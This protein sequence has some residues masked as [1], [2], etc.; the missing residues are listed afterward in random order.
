MLIKK[1]DSTMMDPINCEVITRSDA[2]TAFNRGVISNQQCNSV[3][4]DFKV[5]NVI[6]Q[7]GSFT[8]TTWSVG[9]DR[10]Q[11]SNCIFHNCT[12]IGD[13]SYIDFYNCQIDDVTL[14]HG[15]YVHIRIVD[16]ETTLFTTHNVIA[17]YLTLTRVGLKKFLMPSQTIFASNA[18]KFNVLNIKGCKIKLM[19]Q[20]STFENCTVEHNTFVGY[21][22]SSK[23]LNT[24]LKKN[25]MTKCN[26]QCI[27]LANCDVSL[28]CFEKSCWPNS[29]ISHTVFLSSNFKCSQLKNSSITFSQFINCPFI[30]AE[31]EKSKWSTIRI[32][33]CDFSNVNLTRGNFRDI[34][35]ESVNE[36]NCDWK[37]S[38][39]TNISRSTNSCI[40]GRIFLNILD[41]TTKSN[42][43]NER[44]LFKLILY[45]KDH[46]SEPILLQT[47]QPLVI[48]T[49]N[50][51][52]YI[53]FKIPI[54]YEFDI[55]FIDVKC[56]SVSFGWNTFFAYSQAPIQ[57]EIY[58]SYI[59]LGRKIFY[60]KEEP[61]KRTETYGFMCSKNTHKITPSRNNI[62][63][64]L[65]I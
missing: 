7:Q 43:K 14:K 65:S 28:C 45:T 2:N 42:Y 18:T 3:I 50:I 57:P 59:Q 49:K 25:N 53:Q 24:L 36:F 23:I 31:C 5:C 22:K 11:F 10:V 21:L 64:T 61:Y 44:I 6:F 58:I 46:E 12:F 41:N 63:R 19:V 62:K 48:N 17:N 55:E 16:G 35:L 9:G 38:S 33:D 37:E 4:I 39:I 60:F 32:T 13:W 27:I 29:I 1:Y 54:N 20:S 26:L 40:I 30:F 51:P 47:Q 15:K 52:P 34:H 56:T 8:D